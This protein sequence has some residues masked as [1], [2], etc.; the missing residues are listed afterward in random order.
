MKTNKDESLKFAIRELNIENV[1]KSSDEEF[2][3]FKIITK[4][5]LI[6]KLKDMYNE[7]LIKLYDREVKCKQNQEIYL[8]EDL[9]LLKTLVWNVKEDFI[10]K[11]L[12]INFCFNPEES[13]EK[14]ELYEYISISDIIELSKENI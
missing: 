5:P 1:L 6:R 13:L 9:L 12:Y 7:K 8:E 10:S 3:N 11:E 2:E 4:D 14:I